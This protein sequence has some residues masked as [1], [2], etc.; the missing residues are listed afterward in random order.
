LL[1]I[2]LGWVAIEANKYES[3]DARDWYTT[4]SAFMLICFLILLIFPPKD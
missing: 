3:L 4:G 1:F 2:L